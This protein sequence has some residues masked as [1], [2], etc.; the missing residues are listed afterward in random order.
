MRPDP[1]HLRSWHLTLKGIE[2]NI[3]A[4]GL[5]P[6]GDLAERRPEPGEIRWLEGDILWRHGKWWLSAAIEIA[7]PRNSGRAPV[8]VRFTLID[9]FAVVDQIGETPEGLVRAAIL[10]DG[11]DRLKAERDQRWPRRQPRD[12]ASEAEFRAAQ[13]AIMRLSARIARIRAD[14]L[15]VWSAGIIARANRLTVIMPNLNVLRSAKGTARNWGAAVGTVAAFNRHILGQAPAMAC[16]MLQ[17]KA[18]EAGI[19]CTVAEDPD[20]AIEVGQ[21]LAAETKELRRERRKQRQGGANGL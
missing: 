13:N 1:R 12:P 18:A 14:T 5:V 15:H 11:L 7:R 19:E 6:V 3:F 17:Y 21:T 20:S 2:G 4:R 9:E 8:S 10:A 16:S